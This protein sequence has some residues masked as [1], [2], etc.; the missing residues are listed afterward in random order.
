MEGKTERGQAKLDVKEHVSRSVLSILEHPQT[1][2]FFK[3]ILSYTTVSA[4][5]HHGQSAVTKSH[6]KVTDQCHPC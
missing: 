3:D 5:M 2:N 6:R 4:L 1:G